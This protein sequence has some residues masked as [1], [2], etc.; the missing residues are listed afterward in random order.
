[1]PE[2]FRSAAARAHDLPKEPLDISTSACRFFS[3]VGVRLRVQIQA[4][5]GSASKDPFGILEPDYR[6]FEARPCPL[7]RW[8]TI[9]W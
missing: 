6:D 5:D 9:A 7:P 8:P 3:A 2:G 1:M 4:Q